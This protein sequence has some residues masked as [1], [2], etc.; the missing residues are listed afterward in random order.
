MKVSGM[1]VPK[2]GK[3]VEFK[4]GWTALAMKATGEATRPTAAAA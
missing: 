2:Q 1:R 3:A 4:Y